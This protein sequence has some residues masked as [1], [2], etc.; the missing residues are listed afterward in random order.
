MVPGERISTG[1]PPMVKGATFCGDLG[2]DFTP[3]VLRSFPHER[4]KHLPNN[5]VTKLTK[6]LA[7][8]RVADCVRDSFQ[9]RR[10]TADQKAAHRK[11]NRRRAC[12]YAG[13]LRKR[14]RA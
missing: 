1:Q 3:S 6:M 9:P 5:Y 2:M 7:V 13:G 11:L 12:L 4:K 8:H 10:A 14:A